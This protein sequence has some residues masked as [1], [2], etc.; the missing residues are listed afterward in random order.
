LHAAR[1]IRAAVGFGV[2]SIEQWQSKNGMEPDGLV[3]KQTL[4]TV[5]IV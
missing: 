1:Q 4:R 3:G 2:Q 5:G